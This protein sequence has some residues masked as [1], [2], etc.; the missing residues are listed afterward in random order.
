MTWHIVT[1]IITSMCDQH[2]LFIQLNPTNM[3]QSFT[4][5]FLQLKWTRKMESFGPY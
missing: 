5:G 1:M 4:I 3:T 2:V